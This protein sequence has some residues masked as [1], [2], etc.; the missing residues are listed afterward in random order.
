MSDELRHALAPLFRHLSGVDPSDPTAAIA[1][2]RDLPLS[3]ENMQ[4]LFGHLQSGLE[5]G[6]LTP[7]GEDGMRYGRVC[8]ASEDTHDFSVDAVHMNCPGPG[9]AHPNG[10]INLCFATGGNPAFDGEPPGWVVNAPGT[11]HVPTVTGG[12]MVILYFLPGGAIE[13]GPDPSASPSAS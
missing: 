4:S 13:F 8:K 12:E 1:L 2:N 6:T 7:R 3:S 10:E 9:H 5:A 11:W